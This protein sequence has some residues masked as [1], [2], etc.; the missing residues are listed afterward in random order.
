MMLYQVFNKRPKSRLSKDRLMVVEVKVDLV[1][2][3]SYNFYKRKWDTGV[4]VMKADH[5]LKNYEPVEAA[6]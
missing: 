4:R 1:R 3:I 5:F 2:V 6:A